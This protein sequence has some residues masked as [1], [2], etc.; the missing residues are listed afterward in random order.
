MAKGRPRSKYM[1][2]RNG[3][4]TGRVWTSNDI[5]MVFGL[6]SRNISKYIDGRRYLGKWNF[7]PVYDEEKRTKVSGIEEW[8]EVTNTILSRSVS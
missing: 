4:A 8:N 2:Y 7:K 1:I 3:I 6:D 5:F